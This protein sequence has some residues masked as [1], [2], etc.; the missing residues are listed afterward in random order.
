MPLHEATP[1]EDLRECGY[2]GAFFFIEAAETQGGR[3][4][5]LKQFVGSDRQVVEDLGLLRRTFVLDGII[6][7]RTTAE[8]RVL[9]SFKQSKEAL[10]AALDKGGRGVLSHPFFGRIEDVV[11][12]TWKLDETTRAIGRAKISITFAISDTEG[13]PLPS[14]NQLANIRSLAAAAQATVGSTLATAFSVA[15]NATS[16]FEDAVTKIKKQFA[17]VSS[18]TD[19]LKALAS[20]IDKFNQLISVASTGAAGLIA[21]PT[22]LR[23]SI[24]Q[25]Y[26]GLNG[27]YAT[28]EATLGA[29]VGLFDFGT[30][31]VSTLGVTAQAIERQKNRD[32]LNNGL[33]TLALSYAYENTTQIDFKTVDAIEEAS[34]TLEDQY[35]R[36]FSSPTIDNDVLDTLTELREVTQGFLDEQKLTTRQVI[37]VSTNPTTTRLLAYRYYG[38]DEL[39]DDL[40]ELNNLNFSSFL[41][42]DV[43]VLSQ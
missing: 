8:G 16:N 14:I 19:P 12:R 38:S 31:D 2:R 10:L 23:D 20:N 41:D 9:V 24:L 3:K 36:L 26:T 1:L 25:I 28:V 18:V 30:D 13:L 17:L 43:K 6:A 27:L 37:T 29:F 22:A 11:V 4:D 39:G 33:Q 32:I 5:T 34:N 15:K 40:A 35:Q 42:G 21:A 7:P